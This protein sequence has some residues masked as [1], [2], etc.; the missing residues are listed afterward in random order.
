MKCPKC[1]YLGFDTGDRCRNCGYDFSLTGPADTAGSPLN[2]DLLIKDE[3]EPVGPFMDLSLT[4]GVSERPESLRKRHD[5]IDLDRLIGM[6]DPS[7]SSDSSTLP[8]E[9]FPLFPNDVGADVLPNRPRA[10]PRPPIIVRR[11]TPEAP[12]VPSQQTPRPS[13]T[14][15]FDAPPLA[16]LGLPSTGGSGPFEMSDEAPLPSRVLATL[17]DLLVLAAIDGVV[18]YFTLRLVG[19]ASGD[20]GALPILPLASFFVLLNGG[21]FVTFAAV[22]GQTI[23]QMAFGLKVVGDDGESLAFGTATVR[24]IAWLL[25]TIPLGLG[26]WFALRE[27]HRTLHD[28]LT[29]TRVVLS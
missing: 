3:T 18:L 14:G 9:E 29:A 27:D 6:P 23:G 21:Y 2:T 15:E 16:G 11:Q 4:P 1:G 19:L 10:V 12:G 13:R 5:R 22:G 8:I 26:L 24:T 28:R 7:P 17:V 20:F 25:S